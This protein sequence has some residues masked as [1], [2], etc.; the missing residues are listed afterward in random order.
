MSPGA[1]RH[2]PHRTNLVIFLVDLL[3]CPE[4]DEALD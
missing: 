2:A 4:S 1:S 3:L